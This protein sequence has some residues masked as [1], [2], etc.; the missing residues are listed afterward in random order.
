MVASDKRLILPELLPPDPIVTRQPAKEQR[1]T[2]PTEAAGPSGAI[3]SAS[4][5]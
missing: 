5:A 4:V 3:V 1:L 2:R